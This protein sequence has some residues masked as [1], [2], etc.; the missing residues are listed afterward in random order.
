MMIEVYANA[1]TRYGGAEYGTFRAG[2]VN[3]T[4]QGRRTLA[5]LVLPQIILGGMFGLP[6]ADDM[7][8]VIKAIVRSPVGK[9]LGLQQSD[10]ELAF[11]D[12]MTNTFGPEAMSFA[13]AIARGPIK[14]WGGVDIAQRVSLSPFRSLIEGATGEASS[15]SLLTGPAGAFFG[16]ALN[17]SFDSFTRGDYG[18]SLLRLMPLAMTQNIINAVEAGEE[19]VYTGKGRPL[20]DGLGAHDLLLMTLGFSS[21][22]VYGPRNRLYIEKALA[23]KSNAIKDKYLDKIIRLMV[24]KKNADSSEEKL[25]LQAE[26]N[27][28]YKEVRDHDRE[29]KNIWDKIDPNYNIRRTAVTRY[30]NQVSPAG[31]YRGGREALAIRRNLDLFRTEDNK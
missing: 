15:V 7:K 4:P 27:K 8:E 14:A 10:M 23:T 11:Y 12:I 19:G 29:Q 5:F 13:E 17:K 9:S 2:I 30:I 25:E 21:E 28:L 18:K 24:R 26:M 6:F 22:N 1:I 20:A 3:L 31:R 16:Q